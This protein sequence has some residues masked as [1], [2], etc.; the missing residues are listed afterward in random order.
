MRL[1]ISWHGKRNHDQSGSLF[2]IDYD[3]VEEKPR[4]PV[5]YVY[6]NQLVLRTGFL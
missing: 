5:K 6:N 1:E 3:S 2:A 4:Q